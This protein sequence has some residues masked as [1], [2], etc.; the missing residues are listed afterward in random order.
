MGW[1]FSD[2][3]NHFVNGCSLWPTTFCG[4][5]LGPASFL[6][7]NIF[8]AHLKVCMCWYISCIPTAGLPSNKHLHVHRVLELLHGQNHCKSGKA[9]S[10]TPCELDTLGERPT[11]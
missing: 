1:H 2:V 8:L 3:V 10:G 6:I 5:L 4:F 9:W 7:C 11:Y